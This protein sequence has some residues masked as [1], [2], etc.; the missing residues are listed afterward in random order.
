[1]IVSFFRV[2]CTSVKCKS[3]VLNTKWALKRN[4]YASWSFNIE[5]DRRGWEGAALVTGI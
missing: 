1:M 3:K 5:G 2:K 4:S